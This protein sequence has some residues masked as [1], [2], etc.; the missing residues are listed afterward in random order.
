MFLKKFKS[1]PFVTLLSVHNIKRDI[2]YDLSNPV[3]FSTGLTAI[4][5]I[6]IHTYMCIRVLY[7][8]LVSG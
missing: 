7:V 8:H 3:K 6:N 4:F 5:I 1:F 2:L